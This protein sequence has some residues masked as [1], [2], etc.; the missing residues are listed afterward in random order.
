MKR[1][2]GII[3]ALILSVAGISGAVYFGTQNYE[4][5]AV[6]ESEGVA[7]TDDSITRN[8]LQDQSAEDGLTVD[9]KAYEMSE[10]VYV[11][12][13][14]LFLGEDK[15]SMSSAYPLFVNDGST[16]YC[17]SDSIVAITEEFESV[18]T[19][20]GLY[21]SEGISFN[22]DMERAY[23][24]NFLFL[25]LMNGLYMNAMDMEIK[26]SSLP[27]KTLENNAIIRFQEEKMSWYALNGESFVYDEVT[28][29]N[30]DS[31]V[32]INGVSYIYY[33]L[34]EELGLYGQQKSEEIIDVTPTIGLQPTVALEPTSTVAP[35]SAPTFT[36]TPTPTPV[37][38]EDEEAI[39]GTVN[40][41]SATPTPTTAP[42]EEEKEE[43]P[44]PTKIPTDR[45]WEG[46]ISEM[47]L[48]TPSLPLPALPAA[49][50]EEVEEVEPLETPNIFIPYVP[51]APPQ[52]GG[53]SGTKWKVPKIT[54]GDFSTQVYTVYNEITEI[55]NSE[56]VHNKGIVYQ[57]FELIGEGEEQVEKLATRRA[58]KTK[59]MVKIS[60]LKP[61][62][63]YK[64]VVT[65]NYRTG[66]GT[67]EEVLATQ[68]V[69]TKKLSE[70]PEAEINFS[71]GDSYYEDKAEIKNIGIKD[72]QDKVGDAYEDMFSNIKKVELFFVK[73]GTENSVRFSSGQLTKFKT[74][75]LL[76]WVTGKILES[77]A[78]YEFYFVVYDGHGNAMPNWKQTPGAVYTCKMLP[79][80]SI[81][82]KKNEVKDIEIKIGFENP[83]KAAIEANSVY[84]EIYQRDSAE[85]L[86]T[87]IQR[88]DGLLDL[89]YNKDSGENGRYKLDQEKTTWVRFT[90]LLDYETYTIRIYANYNIDNDALK[91]TET[92]YTQG[93]IGMSKITT[94]PLSSL[95]YTFFNVEV[96]EITEQSANVRIA[97]DKL[98]TNELL[99]NL[100]SYCKI[101]FRPEGE[102]DSERMVIA[103]VDMEAEPDD[104]GG[105]PL[106]FVEGGSL[107]LKTEKEM[108]K[109]RTSDGY[110]FALT[111]LDSRT[112]YEISIVPVVE[113]GSGKHAKSTEITSSFVP[114]DFTTLR[115]APTV[116]INSSICM[117]NS[118]T[119][120][121]VEISDKDAAIING[122]VYMYVFDMFNNN[123]YSYLI[124]V[125][126]DENG[127]NKRVAQ[128]DLKNLEAHHTYTFR[129]YA[130]E[131]NVGANQ[132][133][134]T[135]YKKLEEIYYDNLAETEEVLTITTGEG[136]SGKLDLKS[137][138]IDSIYAK[139]EVRAEDL[140]MKD[141]KGKWGKGV[142]NNQTTYAK[143]SADGVSN[144]NLYRA[145]ST[146]KSKGYTEVYKIE[147]DFGTEGC[148]SFSVG[149]CNNGTVNTS[150][151][152]D[153]YTEDPKENPNAEPVP[154]ATSYKGAT[155][156]GWM[157]TYW[158]EDALF[159]GGEVLRGVQTLYLCQTNQ[160]GATGYTGLVAVRFSKRS[161]ATSGTYAAQLQVNIKDVR[162]EL[163]DNPAYY[164]R[165]YE[166]ESLGQYRL[167]D[168]QLHTFANNGQM[169]KTLE[170]YK[171]MN[172]PTPELVETVPFEAADSVC[173][174]NFN[175]PVKKNREYRIEMMANLNGY[176]IKLGEVS[177]KTG[178]TIN[179]I[180]TFED[181]CSIGQ[182][183]GASYVVT[184][185]IEIPKGWTWQVLSSA[186]EFKGTLNFQGHTLTKNHN[187][188]VFY[189]LAAGSVLENLR[190]RYADDFDYAKYAP[191]ANTGQLVNENYGTIRNLVVEYNLDLTQPNTTF[192]ETNSI[193]ATNSWGGIVEN[194]AVHLKNPMY[195]YKY[196]GFVHTNRGVIRNGY[197]YGEPLRMISRDRYASNSDFLTIR[198]VGAI[199]AGNYGGGLVENCYSSIDVYSM[200]NQN[201]YDGGSALIVGEHEGVIKNCFATGTVYAYDEMAAQKDQYNVLT[202]MNPLFDYSKH[203]P[204]AKMYN[205]FF[206]SEKNVDEYEGTAPIQLK[207][208][209][210]KRWYDALFN[211]SDSAVK[212]Q[213]K[214]DMCTLGF[215]PHVQ[216]SEYMPAQ[217]WVSLPAWEQSS[218]LNLVNA[219]VEEQREQDATVIFT[220]D[221]SDGA[222]VTE[223]SARY[224][225]VIIENQYMQDNLWRVEAVVRPASATAGY[226][227]EYEV[228]GFKARYGNGN[229]SMTTGK[230]Y[231]E[232]EYRTLPVEFYKSVKTVSDWSSIKENMKQNYR[233]YADI[234]FAYYNSKQFVVAVS[235]SN[236]KFEGKLDGNG[237]TISNLIFEEKSSYAAVF[238]QLTGSITNLKVDNLQITSIT[239]NNGKYRGFVGEVTSWATLN[240][241]HLT[242]VEIVSTYTRTGTLIG[243][244]TSSNALV[245]NCSVKNATITSKYKGNYVQ[246]VG[247][248]VGG[249][250]STGVVSIQNCFVDNLKIRVED[251]YACSAVG[252]IIGTMVAGSSIENCYVVNSDIYSAYKATG[253]IIGAVARNTYFTTSRYVMNHVLVD[254]TIRSATDN[255]G[256]FVGYAAVANDSAEIC[257]F[258]LGQV[259]STN[260]ME[261]DGSDIKISAYEGFSDYTAPT[262]LHPPKLYTTKT[263]SVNGE[264]FDPKKAARTDWYK[265]AEEAPEGQNYTYDDF[266][267]FS[268]EEL[269]NLSNYGE[270][271][272]DLGDAFVLDGVTEGRLPKL[273]MLLDQENKE[274]E[275]A[276]LTLQ[277]DYAYRDD[278]IMITKV[279]ATEDGTHTLD[280]NQAY[281]VAI[282]IEHPKGIAIES[283]LLDDYLTTLEENGAPL[284]KKVAGETKTELSYTVGYTGYVD[285]YFIEG[286]R[287]TTA[288][289]MTSSAVQVMLDTTIPERY[290]A[291][292]DAGKWNDNMTPDK[293]GQKGFN[294]SI[295][296]D[297]D[298]ETT[299]MADY[300][301]DVVVNR[302]RGNKVGGNAKISGINLKNKSFV[303]YANGDVSNLDFENISI[304]SE[305]SGSN[306][307]Q[308]VNVIGA[309]RANVKN[310]TIR[311][312]DIN[313][314]NTVK[315]GFIG[316]VSGMIS[317]VTMDGV[318]VRANSNGASAGALVGRV[319]NLAYVDNVIA[320]NIVVAS[321]N[322]YVGGIMGYESES[323]H[324][325]YCSIE[326]FLIYT[327]SSYAGGIGGY[328]KSTVYGTTSKGLTAKNG[329]VLA[330]DGSYAGGIF[331]DGVMSNTA[332]KSLVEN[333]FINAGKGYAGGAYG[334]GYNIGTTTVKDSVVA[335]GASGYIGGLVGHGRVD[336]YGAQCLDTIVT[337][338]YAR[339][340]VNKDTNDNY[341]TY[342]EE[343]KAE[344]KA[345]LDGSAEE[346]MERKYAEAAWETVY[347]DNPSYNNGGWKWKPET[348]KTLPAT[349]PPFIGGAIGNGNAYNVIVANC[350]VGAI[351]ANYVGGIVGR[352]SYVHDSAAKVYNCGI[353][354][355]SVS[356]WSEVGGIVGRT[357]V[358]ATVDCYSATTVKAYDK[359]AGGIIG[360]LMQTN[361]ASYPSSVQRVFTISDVSAVNDYAGGIVGYSDG[362]LQGDNRYYLFAGTVDV[363]DGNGREDRI[364]NRENSAVDFTDTYIYQST[365]FLE[366]ME[367]SSF[368]TA[369]D[370]TGLGFST[371]NW[372]FN[373][374]SKG[375]MPYLQYSTNTRLPGQE[376]Y[377][378][379]TVNG[380]EVK[381]YNAV[382]TNNGGIRIPG[383]TDSTVPST[384]E[385][386]A[387]LSLRRPNRTSAIELPTLTAAY[388][389]DIDKLNLEFDGVA[390]AVMLKIETNGKVIAELPMTKRCY[391]LSYDYRTDLK[392]TLTYAEQ[393]KEY[394]VAAQD[395]AKNIMVWKENYFYIAGMGV[396]GSRATIAGSF[397]HLYEGKALAANGDIYDVVQGT[398][399]GK[400]AGVSLLAETIPFRSAQY[401]E[402][403]VDTYYGY[404]T[405]DGVVRDDMR[406]Y[407]KGQSLFAV[408]PKLTEDY[409]AIL[410]DDA[411]D[412]ELTTVLYRGTIKDLTDVNIAMPK[413]FENA[414]IWQMTNNLDSDSCY[415]LVRY[416]DG[417]V[418]GFNYM[419]GDELPIDT[420]RVYGS[421]TDSAA[422]QE[423]TDG[424]NFAAAYEEMKQF[425]SN[426]IG[427]GWTPPEEAVEEEDAEDIETQESVVEE[428]QEDTIADATE[429]TAVS[430][431]VPIPTWPVTPTPLPEGTE[432]ATPSEYEAAESGKDDSYLSGVTEEMQEYVPQEKEE[433]GTVSGKGD[434]P[435]G[436]GS[437]DGT[438]AT[439]EISGNDNK[440]TAGGSAGGGTLSEAEN[441]GASDADKNP[442]VQ[443]TAEEKS[444]KKEPSGSYIPYFDPELGEYVIFD[445]AELLSKSEEKPISMN[446]QVRR[447]GHMIEKY[448]PFMAESIQNNQDN[449]LGVGL[450]SIT[451]LV[452]AA[453]IV[454]L[455]IKQKPDG[456]KNEEN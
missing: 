217:T 28:G 447:S 304:R 32:T 203:G 49:P 170:I 376:G 171:L 426:L 63:N 175:Y 225:E 189:R 160:E 148:N 387:I 66:L 282:T 291:I 427:S 89:I 54:L 281:T 370:G 182:D 215:Y 30:E 204:S 80:A 161:V 2:Y 127:E 403:T 341:Q 344:V 113:M 386:A 231:A 382:N 383:W 6:L 246:V 391:T 115:Q 218:E 448:S 266:V 286:Y 140:W 294:I 36:P 374:L 425:E 10:M 198:R 163:G 40:R 97:L 208:L 310:I 264:V 261:S 61:E 226:Y 329:A 257:G 191:K 247:G 139:Y 323:T 39:P 371:K 373:G 384:P 319:N 273:K 253:G 269:C 284:V 437:E 132:D 368:Y 408:A 155:T 432:Y 202:D 22:Q 362:V 358:G 3:A 235:T 158:T 345:V 130:N 402:S 187:T 315:N 440:T 95:G 232:S 121:D 186:Q 289:A 9:A 111:G 404:S 333:V 394:E 236:G 128:I 48:L 4:V 16:L 238:P 24:E 23:R 397:V 325:T 239:S 228:T 287:Y 181:L 317:G 192:D 129:F 389:A 12:N 406:L 44:K 242:D 378:V 83:D 416:A 428:Q 405:V 188:L 77:N 108:E 413:E 359:Y 407:V 414:D 100:L 172:V 42:Q 307:L 444:K 122:P 201:V 349:Y 338:V 11:K 288:E 441:A 250:E 55:E 173:D 301:N 87:E 418:A 409:D 73:D 316:E 78:K 149:Y 67:K 180:E 120:Y 112:K 92:V 190:V 207:S 396:E 169:E 135:Y 147:Y 104:E 206:Y 53:S 330:K 240:N 91:K 308:Y 275:D 379:K 442:E 157:F 369:T 200:K 144:P 312:V 75:E 336:R 241:V 388:S 417:A 423:K 300:A 443:E 420:V 197:V 353:Q 19:Y 159:A 211:K 260:T 449:R 372:S 451:L 51:S 392:L 131:I 105:Y 328:A 456:V 268:Y 314:Q 305:N 327:S 72:Y 146:W 136:L 196:A 248:L 166:K 296:G 150:V 339:S 14:R 401:E 265:Y 311:D 398:V 31:I 179:T 243:H 445:K 222:V 342:Y 395:V 210:D 234:D 446:E 20:Q 380:V 309:A 194:F 71:T 361:N 262:L 230:E 219:T 7:I 193:I 56:F 43:Q 65:L 229:G 84:F 60:G 412:G 455:M 385:G 57:V 176:V 8:L 156:R 270:F 116:L 85:P 302:L 96:S 68:E 272:L 37:Q 365:A 216:M 366:D 26:V 33:E 313:V 133:D 320:K 237:H 221:N 145:N 251:A 25:E 86:Q 285:R 143:V 134:K 101:E 102:T 331:G 50:A 390:E 429:Q 117:S 324:I 214:L 259:Y 82:L 424:T 199:V 220:F 151:K 431:P 290:L 350:E 450:F 13:G 58:V 123:I 47:P 334:A 138:D 318:I 99:L 436:A 183:L 224:L 252:G 367:D 125:G 124:P 293:Y 375:W 38:G 381:E 357:I 88:K 98:R 351:H 348:W 271:G 411:A 1:I 244:S 233:L 399:C 195:F 355:G 185:D 178:E 295:E 212:N 223:I 184:R 356:G 278:T 174:V 45:E 106:K 421:N 410:V 79:Q 280:G 340:T 142:S 35:T 255:L 167:A 76:D 141:K 337:T 263:A 103:Y 18:P 52:S 343:Q 276:F 267:Y 205:N 322:S 29:L 164:L 321:N 64:V 153:I 213:F 433:S 15:L 306:V 70:L 256:G 303:K 34:L 81:E 119:L 59:G 332:D 62:T 453:L 110:S 93:E 430:W 46:E 299:A 109:L 90:G 298:F 227:S 400:V 258:F 177:F 17:L 137:I 439:G 107:L 69:T 363:T 165:I 393:Q 27:R 154:L 415:V 274:K 326:N 21:V 352:Q 126:V 277:P 279:T 209:Y 354:G 297:L 118:I 249:S 364:G 162:K 360:R 254:A 435:E 347:A 335:G 438:G 114:T 452:I 434:A 292:A 422:K 168:Y 152:Y 41:P 283:I 377:T 74:G 454:A 419:T 94:A 5:Y 346:S 245:H